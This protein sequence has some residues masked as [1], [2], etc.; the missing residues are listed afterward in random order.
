MNEQLFKELMRALARE[1]AA[2]RKAAIEDEYAEL[3]TI[4]RSKLAKKVLPKYS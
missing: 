1:D 4:L 3:D 2:K